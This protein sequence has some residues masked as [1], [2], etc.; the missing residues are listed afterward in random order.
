MTETQPATSHTAANPDRYDSER[1]FHD[2]RFE[3]SP[4][5]ADSFYA[6]NTACADHYRELLGM[7]RPNSR[8]LEYGCGTGSSAFYLASKGVHVTGIDISSVAIGQAQQQATLEGLEVATF[9]QMNAE[10]LGFAHDRFELVCGSG[11]LHHLDLRQ[12]ME[13]VHRVLTPDGRAVFVEPMG[14]NPIIN[15][16][17]KLTPHERTE[18]EHPFLIC[19]FELLEDFFSAV[20]VQ[21]FVLIALL[22]IPFANR[23]GFGAIIRLLNR[24]DGW[25]FEHVPFLRRYSWTVLLQLADPVASADASRGL[26][27]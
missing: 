14:H 10:R 13:E 15:L 23:P 11:I 27:C 22:G 19:D 8:A 2:R 3:S 4:R 25:L 20:D 24:A 18:D 26:H 12:A 16:Y 5:R 21:H 6:V 17:R 7:S 9:A 1:R